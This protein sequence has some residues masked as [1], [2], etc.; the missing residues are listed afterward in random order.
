MR[1]YDIF[2]EMNQS[3]LT[4][5]SV[6]SAARTHGLN[7]RL[8]LGAVKSGRIKTVC[9]SGRPKISAEALANFV[10]AARSEFIQDIAYPT[11]ALT[12]QRK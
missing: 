2:A 10:Q 11:P 4:L 12:N 7:Y 3:K 8:L 1:N 9:L 5:V 6:R